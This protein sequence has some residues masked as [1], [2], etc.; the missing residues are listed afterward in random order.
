[1][2][3]FQTLLIYDLLKRSYVRRQ[4]GLYVIPCP[5]QEFR[6]LEGELLLGLSETRD[7]LILWDLESGHIKGRIKASHRESLLSRTSFRDMKSQDIPSREPT[8]LVMPWDRRTETHSA[9]KRRLERKAQREK[10]EQRR[11]DREKHNSVDQYLLS[12]DEQVLVCSYFAH[13]LVVFSVV[14]Q[15]HLH[16]LEDRASM[17]FLYTAALTYSGSHLVL[18]NYND[19]ERVSYVT[20]WDLRKGRVRKRLKNEPDVCCMAISTDGSR[21]AFGITGTNRLRVWDPFRKI[22][23]NIT[24]YENLTMSVNSQLY[25]TEEGAKAIL[26]AGEVSLWDLDA[27]TVLSVFT[28]DSRIQCLSLLGEDNTLLLG[29]S[30]SPTLVTLKL[31]SQEPSKM[32]ASGDDLFG[33]ESSEDEGDSAEPQ[34]TSQP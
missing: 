18:S 1:M 24:G 19:T 32:S 20:L 3:I 27:S 11:M 28:P 17:L 25:V 14:S 5:Q 26:L 29:L 2:P 12:G 34:Q 31:T 6:L 8:A 16:T 22:H 33:E 30:D 4:C 15:D 23:K 21:V 10:E 7:H 9:K 13:H